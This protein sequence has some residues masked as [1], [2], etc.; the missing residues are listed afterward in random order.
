[1]SG[2]KGKWH[3][4]SFKVIG[5]SSLLLALSACA[6]Q[7]ASIPTFESSST[8]ESEKIEIEVAPTIT[9]E[10]YVQGLRKVKTLMLDN[11]VLSASELQVTSENEYKDFIQS[12]LNDPQSTKRVVQFYQLLLQLEGAMTITNFENP[13]LNAVIDNDEPSSLA[14]YLYQNDLDFR[15][16]LTADYCVSN[17]GSGLIPKANCTTQGRRNLNFDN[18]NNPAFWVESSMPQD[19]R[20][21]ALSTQAFLNRFNGALDF[22]RPAAAREYFLCRNYPDP[23][24]NEGWTKDNDQLHPF[25]YTPAGADLDCQGCHQTLNKVRGFFTG[26]GRYGE[27]LMGQSAARLDNRLPFTVPARTINYVEASTIALP[28]YTTI[29]G[30]TTTEAFEPQVSSYH[31]NSISTYRA[32]L[33]SPLYPKLSD[34]GRILSESPYFAECT[35]QRFYNLA[36]GINQ[37]INNRLPS[38]MKEKLIPALENSNFNLKTLLLEIFSSSDFLHQ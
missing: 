6:Q 32:S 21:G 9:A 30:K 11:P 25:Y 38:A 28:D 10:D 35:A 29:Y 16:I 13:S 7:I 19:M 2:I 34:Y 26:F 24:E 17:L 1:M 27:V 4:D 36:L 12:Y 5:L 20:A 18:A 8:P 3:I 15:G 14:G 37:N 31:G 33:S 23:E 22:R